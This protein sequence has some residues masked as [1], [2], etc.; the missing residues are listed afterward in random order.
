MVF[1]RAW[2]SPSMSPSLRMSRTLSLP[3][4]SITVSFSPR[5]V[6]PQALR[7][8]MEGSAVYSNWISWLMAAKKLYFI[9]SCSSSW[10]VRSEAESS[11]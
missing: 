9:R 3:W 1:R 5:R 2:A 7:V 11:S 8:T 4:G 10:R 6:A